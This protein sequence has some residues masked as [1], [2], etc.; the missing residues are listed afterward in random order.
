[1][2]ILEELDYQVWL[3]TCLI[4]SLRMFYLPYGSFV[5]YTIN[6]SNFRVSYESTVE[7]EETTKWEWLHSLGKRISWQSLQLL[8]SISELL[9]IERN[10]LQ[11][12]GKTNDEVNPFKNVTKS[13]QAY[14]FNLDY[15][16]VCNILF[17]SFCPTVD[18]V[19][20][21]SRSTVKKE[22]HGIL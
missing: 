21:S 8:L 1:M 2:P 13:N 6:T 4:L 12:K 18:G 5:V 17:C 3:L 20:S 7:Q 14:L 19:S 11:V 10:N 15:P 9:K 16:S 22:L